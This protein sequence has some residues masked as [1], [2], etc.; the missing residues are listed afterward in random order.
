MATVDSSARAIGKGLLDT[1]HGL[2]H[3]LPQAESG[4]G[5]LR[6]LHSSIVLIG[7]GVEVLMK[8]V[9][10]HPET[11]AQVIG[12]NL[13]TLWQEIDPARQA[14]IESDYQ[15]RASCSTTVEDLLT[16]CPAPFEQIRYWYEGLEEVERVDGT[17]LIRLGEALNAHLL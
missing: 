9:I 15:T 14:A 5:Q 7:F 3:Q 12:H 10:M 13:T 6:L 2:M 8:A 17:K 1:G 4:G 16:Q 11:N